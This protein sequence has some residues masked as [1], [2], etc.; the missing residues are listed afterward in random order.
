VSQQASVSWLRTQ[1][2]MLDRANAE[3]NRIA[4]EQSTPT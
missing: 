1:R 4:R 2:E 3:L